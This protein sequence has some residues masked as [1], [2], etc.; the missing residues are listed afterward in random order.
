MQWCFMFS[1]K[2]GVTHNMIDDIHNHWKRAEAVR[3]KCL[4]VPT[5]DMDNICFHLEV[6]AVL[7]TWGNTGN[8]IFTSYFV[9][10]H[11]SALLCRIKQVGK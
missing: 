6:T 10:S 2:G 5:L 9:W 8:Y 7:L 1:G 4:G 11:V 3:I